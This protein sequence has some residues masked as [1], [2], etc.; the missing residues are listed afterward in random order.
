MSRHE[1]AWTGDQVWGGVLQRRVRSA[2]PCSSHSPARSGRRSGASSRTSTLR[3]RSS[4]SGR[5]V[6]ARPAR[7]P[8]RAPP[9]AV[10]SGA[11]HPAPPPA[12][13]CLAPAPPVRAAS[14]RRPQTRMRASA[15]ARLRTAQAS[16]LATRVLPACTPIRAMVRRAC[17]CDS[18]RA[19][20]DPVFIGVH[21]R[22]SDV[23]VCSQRHI[24]PQSTC[25][26]VAR[27]SRQR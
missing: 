25:K 17:P 9:P 19:P 4:C 10:P 2:A 3:P 27:P 1:A 7:P 14:R 24:S 11:C 15:P 22:V 21:T 18:R 8:L 12:A 20:A 16:S 6:T 23:C 5:C 26:E 13:A